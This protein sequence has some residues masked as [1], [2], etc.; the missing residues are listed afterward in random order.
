[1]PKVGFVVN[2]KG[3]RGRALQAWQKIEAALPD[4]GAYFTTCPGDATAKALE[5]VADG[6]ERV[7]VVGG[8]GS[9]SEA[10]HALAGKDAALAVVPVGTGNDYAR[11]LGVPTDAV[12]AAR[13]AFD[14]QTLRVDTGRCEGHRSFVNVAGAGFDAEVMT[15]FNAPGPI[16][17]RM[18]VKVRYYLSILRTFAS[19]KG[20]KA[21]V[22]ADGET[23]EVGNLLLLAV[24][25]ARYYGAGMHVL[26]QADLT[27]GLFDVVW[28][29]DVRLAELNALMSLIYKGE[30]VGHPNV[31]YRKCRHVSVEARPSTRFHLDGDVTG[32]TPVTFVTEPASLNVVVVAD[33]SKPV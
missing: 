26:P 1:M 13:L 11:T 10:A 30:H 19:Y 21:T 2:P 7:A 15:R 6:C 22:V 18:P 23:V 33:T 31:R 20:V 8:D 14:G 28:G 32:R 4:A 25:C 17:G 12:E 27:D 29:Q 16:V 3:G 24:G 5:A 9:V